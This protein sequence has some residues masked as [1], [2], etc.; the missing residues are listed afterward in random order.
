MRLKLLA[1]A[2]AA[3]VLSACSSSDSDSG[4]TA[5]A[6]SGGGQDAFIQAIDKAEVSVLLGRTP[7][8]SELVNAGEQFCDRWQAAIDDPN[9]MD[10]PLFVRQELERELSEEGSVLLGAVFIPAEDHLCPDLMD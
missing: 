5:G 10:G 8:D 2:C 9:R 3:V 4:P 6:D 1:V 7:T